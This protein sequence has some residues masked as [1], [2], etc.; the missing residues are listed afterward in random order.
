MNKAAIIK[1]CPTIWTQVLMGRQQLYLSLTFSPEWL[2]GII[3]GIGKEAATKSKAPQTR[4]L[5]RK[6]RDSSGKVLKE[7]FVN[8]TVTPKNL[9]PQSEIKLGSLVHISNDSGFWID[10]FI[11]K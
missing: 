8:S 3:L 7:R 2:L 10:N 6:A 1:V 9:Q 4:S 5:I 11:F